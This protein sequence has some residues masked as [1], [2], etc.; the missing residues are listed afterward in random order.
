MTID[1]Q[2]AA[3][4]QVR[5]SPEWKQVCRGAVS[6]EAREKKSRGTVAIWNISFGEQSVL[7]GK[8]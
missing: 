6:L 4:F 1:L 8:A 5:R 3:Q 7:P 2:K